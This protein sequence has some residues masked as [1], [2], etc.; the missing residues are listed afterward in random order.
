LRESGS[1]RS[2]W[3][4]PKQ[5]S[6]IWR[7]ETTTRRTKNE[8]NINPAISAQQPTVEIIDYAAIQKARADAARYS[9]INSYN[10]RIYFYRKAISAFEK[11][12][13]RDQNWNK[14]RPLGENPQT[15]IELMTQKMAERECGDGQAYYKSVII[16]YQQ[17]LVQFR[18]KMRK[19]LSKLETKHI[20][21]KP[22]SQTVFSHSPRAS[23]DVIYKTIPR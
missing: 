21:T 17:L 6:Q 15:A 5:R 9:I 12:I 20:S 8:N 18:P 3:R 19:L 7:A 1:R 13:E 23:P 14:P 10:Q 2:A 11:K 22:R 4:A 16:R